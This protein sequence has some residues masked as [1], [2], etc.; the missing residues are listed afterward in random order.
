MPRR[1]RRSSG[2]DLIDTAAL[3]R[4]MPLVYAIVAAVLVALLCEVVAP[5]LAPL[6]QKADGINFAVVFLP[7]VQII[8]GFLAGS[9][10]LFGL[11][12]A[13]ARWFEGRSDRF[14]LDAQT[15]IESVRRLSW[16]EFERLLGEVYRRQGYEVVQ[17]GGPMADGGADLELRRDGERLLV[18]AKHWKERMVRLPQVRELW[19][20]V[21]DEHADGAILVTSGN[22]TNDAR[23]WTDKKNLTLVDGIELGHLVAKMSSGPSPNAVVPSG[24]DHLC[25]NCGRPMVVRVARKGSLAGQSFWGCTGYPSCR[26]TEPIAT[27]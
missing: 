22:F 5:L 27:S 6:Y 1:S 13:A 2:S 12:G 8:G 21:A 18:Q 23:R 25:S 20:A 7:F 9:I 11:W 19:G 10:L 3:F 26:H 24:H 16:Q 15:G 17:R 14:R 4:D